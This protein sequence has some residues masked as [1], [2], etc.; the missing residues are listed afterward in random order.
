MT[1]NN[2]DLNITLAEL[3]RLQTRLSSLEGRKFRGE[4]RLQSAW[5][6]ISTIFVL[7]LLGLAAVIGLVASQPGGIALINEFLTGQVPPS[8]SGSAGSDTPPLP[9]TDRNSFPQFMTLFLAVSAGGIAYLA[10]A[11]GMKRLETYDGQFQEFRRETRETSNGIE[12]RFQQVESKLRDDIDTLVKESLKTLQADSEKTIQESAIVIRNDIEQI[13]LDV[14]NQREFLDN[15]FGAIVDNAN[16]KRIL[17]DKP[18]TGE[19]HGTVTRL[20]LQ[21]KSSEARSLVNAALEFR[22]PETHKLLTTGDPDDWF[23]LCSQLGQNDEFTLGLKV[24][25]AGLVQQ[26][27]LDVSCIDDLRIDKTAMLVNGPNFKTMLRQEK[28]PNVDLFAHALNYAEKLG[29]TEL[30]QSLEEIG[31]LI[32]VGYR[33]WRYYQFMCDHYNKS[34]QRDRFFELLQELRDRMP[35]EERGYSLELEWYEARSDTESLERIGRHWLEDPNRRGNA[36]PLRLARISLDKG[37]YEKALEYTGRA[38]EGSA[39]AQPTASIG[40]ILFYRANAYDAQ[41]M[42]HAQNKKPDCGKLCRLF[43]N[44]E[45]LYQSEQISDTSTIMART[46]K[47]RIEAMRLMLLEAGCEPLDP[48]NK[49]NSGDNPPNHPEP[50]APEPGDGG[51]TVDSVLAK[52]IREALERAP[53]LLNLALNAAGKGDLEAFGLAKETLSALPIPPALREKLAEMLTEVSTDDDHP[54]AVRD[55]AIELRDVLTDDDAT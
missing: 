6:S 51:P 53:E 34:N 36:V 31:R 45:R 15:K 43:E 22:D 18:S 17:T 38:L 1:E 55:A 54:D 40:A 10:S 5:T 2:S 3:R 47:R 20:F 7:V 19:L 30:V 9:P 29:E 46:A 24:A 16:A 49:P 21:S 41:L 12:D 32:P 50:N 33:N 28:I 23:N 37:D 26:R 8:G 11:M 13:Q 4:G 44:A 25:L 27:S 42:K 14:V 48:P 39:E 52:E 35:H